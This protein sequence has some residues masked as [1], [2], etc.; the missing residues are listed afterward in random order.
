MAEHFSEIELAE[1]EELDEELAASGEELAVAELAEAQEHRGFFHELVRLARQNRVTLILAA[2]L[3]VF[4][5]LLQNVMTGDIQR[6]DA[7]AYQIFVVLARRSWLTPVMEGFS[8]L[9]S[10]VILAVTLLVVGAFAPGRAPGWCAAINLVCAVGL[11]YVLK[12]VVQRPR[13]EG[14][15]LVAESGYSFPSGHSM[16]SMAFYGLLIW[17]V[18]HYE[19]N[20]LLRFLF[21]LALTGIIVLVGVSRIY[22]GVHYASDVLAGFAVALVWIMV[23]TRIIVPAFMQDAEVIDRRPGD[24]SV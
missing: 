16:V 9:A 1:L 8:A 11:N 20:R 21:V 4:L 12:E 22:L 7:A 6:L 5:F 23:Y 18:W 3:L 2:A 14:F 13:P 10:P 15:R 17:M 24:S 19:K